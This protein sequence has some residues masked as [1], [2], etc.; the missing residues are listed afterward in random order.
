[1]ESYNFDIKLSDGKARFCESYTLNKQHIIFN[2]ESQP[3]AEARLDRIYINIVDGSATLSPAII[4]AIENGE[5]DYKD[6][7]QF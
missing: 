5:F 2:Y 7:S 3:R 4:K 1:L 6:A